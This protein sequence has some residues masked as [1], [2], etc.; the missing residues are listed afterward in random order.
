QAAALSSRYDDAL[1]TPRAQVHS[2]RLRPPLRPC[3]PIA[4]RTHREARLA[5]SPPPTWRPKSA[6]PLYYPCLPGGQSHHHHLCSLLC[7]SRTTEE[8]PTTSSCAPVSQHSARLSPPSAALRRPRFP[9]VRGV[10]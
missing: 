5:A 3:P 2:P 1:P 9:S 6:S 4:I 7:S 8:K 10:N